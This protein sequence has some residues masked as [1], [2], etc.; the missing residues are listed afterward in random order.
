MGREYSRSPALAAALRSRTLGR[1]MTMES[2]RETA[3]RCH[4]AV[5]AQ[6]VA[7]FALVSLAVLV[8]AI[9]LTRELPAN[10]RVSEQVANQ[11]LMREF[12]RPEPK[13]RAIFLIALFSL[14]A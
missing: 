10:P 6:V 7:A 5:A 9:V 4:D 14:P 12:L 3:P 2:P 11:F 13:E 1:A 8:L